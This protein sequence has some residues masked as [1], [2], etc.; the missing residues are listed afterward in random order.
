MPGKQ[1]EEAVS[2]NGD[3]PLIPPEPRV[4]HH[5]VDITPKSLV[6]MEK[7]KHDRP[8]NA[9]GGRNISVSAMQPSIYIP[10]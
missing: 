6:H 8:K 5:L 9:K 10:A 4:E 3:P 7:T 1:I 2:L